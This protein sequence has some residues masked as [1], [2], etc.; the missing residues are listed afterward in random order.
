MK[1][2]KKELPKK[3]RQKFGGSWTEEKL[4]MIKK[5][6][7]AYATIMNQKKFKFA[8]VD[9]FA[10]TGYRETK[11]SGKKNA[12]EMLFTDSLTGDEP[13]EFMDGSA[14]IALKTKPEFDKYIFIEKNPERFAKLEQLKT[15]SSEKSDQIILVNEDANKYLQKFCKADWKGHRA[16]VFL[17]PFGMQVTWQTLTA[18]ANTKAIDLWI[19]FPLGSGVSRLLKR[20]GEIPQTWKEKLNNLFG[21]DGWYDEFYQKSQQ[22]SLFADEKLEKVADFNSIADY[23]VRRLKTIF[24]HVHDKPLRLMNSKDVPLFLLCF[25]AGNDKGGKVALKIANDILRS[26]DG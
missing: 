26:S 16:V 14:T 23:F 24:P 9:A 8:Y 3:G 7:V 21:E 15:D 10:G 20:D 18:I 4:E 13:Q 5:Y 17:D 19:L 12:E 6:L 25:A 22:T 2:N 11:K 1:K